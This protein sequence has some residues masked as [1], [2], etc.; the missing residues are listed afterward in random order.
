MRLLASTLLILPFLSGAARAQSL[1][2]FDASGSPEAQRIGAAAAAKFRAHGLREGRPSTR[3][4]PV[5]GMTVTDYGRVSVLRDATHS[6]WGEGLSVGSLLTGFDG[7]I[8]AYYE[9]H[10][11][12]DPQYVMIIADWLN[13]GFP[14]AFYSP[15]AN[16]VAGI[17]YRNQ[18]DL[19]GEIFDNDPSS[20]LEGAIYMNGIQIFTTIP[21]HELYT[22]ILWGQEFAHRWGT[23][24]HFDDAGTESAALLGRQSAHW[25]WYVDSDWS[26]MEGNRWRNNNDGTFTTDV[27]NFDVDTH[28]NPMDLY[29][30]G[31][32]GSADVPSFSLLAHAVAGPDIGTAPDAWK[33][34]THTIAATARSVSVQ[35]VIAV[36][37]P[38]VPD[39][40]SSPKEFHVAVLYV[41]RRDDRIDAA[42]LSTVETVLDT[43]I[44]SW[45]ADVG[46]RAV[47][48][49]GP[50]G[51]PNRAPV[52]SL[53][54]P[55]EGM[56]HHPV[57]FDASGATDPDGAAVRYFWRFDSKSKFV[58]GG[59][60]VERVFGT[61]GDKVVE[62]SVRD[63][64]GGETIVTHPL[65]VKAAGMYS[66]AVARGEPS[67][68]A[69]LLLAAAALAIRRR[70]T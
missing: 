68:L 37:G 38:R 47:V 42:K 5:N 23:F 18:T 55:D 59:P 25:S 10:P 56:Q 8:S 15:V 54:A 28:Y 45:N 34:T 11:D 60:V 57:R 48:D 61:E 64:E 12:A 27:G 24:V 31:L 26:W 16:D 20:A 33:A 3:S 63:A 22:R 43:M 30:M 49:Y 21:N 40:V 32:I 53:R 1:E 4:A 2:P 7:S 70:R 69:S 46:G 13:T 36:E 66:C 41:L 39:F 44:A 17:G 19:P 50:F 14:G 29:L 6:N 35:D 65:H 52:V 62:V 51:T 58:E 67:G 9:A